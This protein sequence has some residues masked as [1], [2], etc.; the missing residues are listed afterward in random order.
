[1]RSLLLFSFLFF[2]ISGFSQ[3]STKVWISLFDKRSGEPVPN[4]QLT[5]DLGGKTLLRKSDQKGR[6]LFYSKQGAVDLGFTHPLY[7]SLKTTRRIP[8]EDSINIEIL[9]VP[10]RSQDITEVVVKAPGVPD[11]IY[12]SKRLSV[13]DFEIQSNGDLVLLA[14]PKNLKKGSELLLYN[15][16]E[17]LNSFVIPGVAQE[18][19]RDYRGNA[20]V[21][22]AE[23]VVGLHIQSGKIG[24]STLD[25]EYYLKYLAPILDTNHTKLFFS[26]FSKDYPAFSYFSF[27]QLDSTYKK[28][29]NVQDD[30]MMELYRSE[31][32]WVDVR[33]KLWAKEK[34]HQTGIDA[35][36]WVGANY[37]TQSI[38]YKELYAPMFHR[39]DTL[40]VFDYYKDMLLCYSAHGDP[41]DS[42]PIYH[43]YNPRSTGWKKQLI[44]DRITGEIYAVYDKA[45]FTYLGNVNVTTGLISELVR[46]EYR[47]VDKLAVHNNAV[48]YVYRPFESVQKRFLYKEKLP[49]SF[50]KSTVPDGDEG[51]FFVGQ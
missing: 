32:K 37:F 50:G 8:D 44:Q 30:L 49:Y 51:D 11:T 33:T 18:L 31:Y 47:Y 39:N 12:Q 27:D 4:V 17:V 24:I 36:I 48:Y 7:E 9:L 34:E 23:N 25:K 38:Y 10:I 13:A 19:V 21:V 2:L 43:H 45:G 40:F 16:V 3:D 1:M 15:G 22:C 26:N 6:I 42:I 20:H 29:C 14:Y 35:E 5:G 41:I 46:L 28:I